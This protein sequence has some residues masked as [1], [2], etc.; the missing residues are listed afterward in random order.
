M[1]NALRELVDIIK[2]NIRERKIT[3]ELARLTLQK[4]YSNSVLGVAWAFIR[5]MVYVLVFY[6]AIRIGLRGDKHINGVPQLLWLV[7]GSFIWFFISNTIMH[8]GKS[9]IKNRHLVTKMVFPISTIPI[10]SVSAEFFVHLILMLFVI[11]LYLVWGLGVSIYYLQL[12]YYLFCVF[13]F[14][15]ILAVF[16][17]AISAI[18]RDVSYLMPSVN[19][20]L[21]WLSPILWPLKNIKSHLIVTIV[22]L[23]PVAYLVEGVRNCFVYHEWFF[24]QWH[25]SLYFWV[26]MIVFA[27][28]TAR[29]WARSKT[30]F[31]DVL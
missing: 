24:E 18:S 31:A 19:Q 17:S 21:F 10:I 7:P 5:P 11:V 9:L 26:L 12:I 23:N 3:L 25:Y 1:L 30:E 14:C 29:V 15:S 2:T 20:A 16:I 6:F 27:L 13:V 28:I 4:E 22:K 8:C